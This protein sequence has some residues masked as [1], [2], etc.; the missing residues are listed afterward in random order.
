MLFTVCA[1]MSAQDIIL[2]RDSDIIEANVQ[3]IS[4]DVIIYKAFDNPDGPLYRMATSKII[5]IKFKNGTEQ[6]FNRSVAQSMSAPAA[7]MPSSRLTYRSGDLYCGST[8]LT[9]ADMKSIMPVNLYEQANGGLN[10]RNHGKRLV[11]AGSVLSAV[12]IVSAAVA[13]SQMY[14]YDYNYGYVYYDETAFAF[15][16]TGMTVMSSGLTCLAVGVP[17]YCVGQSR[18]KKAAS[19]YNTSNGY[20]EVSFNVGSTRNGFGLFMN[21]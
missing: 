10:M 8:K 1:S 3:E 16:W 7:S 17:L 13:G 5:K 14:R 2:T 12:G 15:Y 20:P 19:A 18:A 6:T 4:D 9:D 11:I 21:F